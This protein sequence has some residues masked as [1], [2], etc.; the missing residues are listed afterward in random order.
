MNRYFRSTPP[1]VLNLIIINCLMLLATQPVPELLAAD[2]EAFLN[3]APLTW[4]DHATLLA[5]HQLNEFKPLMTRIDPV[6]V[7]AMTD[8]SKEDLTASQTD[9]GNAAPQGNG[10]LIKE[11][12]VTVE[13]AEIYDVIARLHGGGVTGIVQ[14]GQQHGEL[15]AAQPHG[16]VVAAG[17]PEQPLTDGAQHVVADGMAGT[18]H[19]SNQEL[20]GQGIA[21]VLAP[22]FGGFA[23]TGLNLMLEQPA[24]AAPT[25][26]A[27]V[28]AAAALPN[29]KPPS[30]P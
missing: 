28:P 11:P 15:L 14:L 22:L 26:S 16:D 2:A 3:V 25:A 8:A 1:V 20:I 7:Q 13:K 9:T 18:R 29:N 23:A 12:L 6:K 10:E 27:A 19:D 5:N 24:A 30:W 17:R 4:N 21:N